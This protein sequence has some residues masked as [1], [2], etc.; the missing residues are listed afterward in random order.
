MFLDVG[1][2]DLRAK[3]LNPCQLR[4]ARPLGVVAALQYQVTMLEN[5]DNKKEREK[6]R[7]TWELLHSKSRGLSS[8]SGSIRAIPALLKCKSRS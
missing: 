6:K 1:S 8:S 3:N 5:V 4:A 2:A 7:R